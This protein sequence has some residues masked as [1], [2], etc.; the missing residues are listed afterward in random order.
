LIV[1]GWTQEERRTCL[2][3]FYEW[4]RS[5]LAGDEDFKDE[6][7][8]LMKLDARDQPRAEDDINDNDDDDDEL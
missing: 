8:G 7:K 3:R 1:E 2:D 4:R 5:F 6:E